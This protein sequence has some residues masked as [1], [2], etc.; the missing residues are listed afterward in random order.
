MH[1]T[2]RKRE[3]DVARTLV[4]SWKPRARLKNEDRGSR[5]CESLVHK[6]CKAP[7]PPFLPSSVSAYYLRMFEMCFLHCR[8]SLN[9]RL[10]VSE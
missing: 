10:V 2:L 8:Y 7:P 3:K 6:V 9:I 1:T 5:V 4:K